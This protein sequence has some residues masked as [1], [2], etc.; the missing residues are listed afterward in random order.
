MRYIAKYKFAIY[1]YFFIFLII[2]LIYSSCKWAILYPFIKLFFI[3]AS[4]TNTSYL[5]VLNARFFKGK[6]QNAFK[7]GNLIFKHKSYLSSVV[8]ELH[9]FILELNQRKFNLHVNS[10]G[11]SRFKSAINIRQMY[12][13]NPLKPTSRRERIS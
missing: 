13:I 11:F 6:K 4:I 10:L 12:F 8:A 1:S 3:N 2:T 7:E 9:T 5:L